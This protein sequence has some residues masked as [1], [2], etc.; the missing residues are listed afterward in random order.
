MTLRGN[1]EKYRFCSDDI[2]NGI[3]K[4]SQVCAR[5]RHTKNAAEKIATMYAFVNCK[6]ADVEFPKNYPIQ[7][8]VAISVPSAENLGFTRQFYSSL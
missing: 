1:G 2:E 7:I 6:A 5:G 8:V 3:K 4:R